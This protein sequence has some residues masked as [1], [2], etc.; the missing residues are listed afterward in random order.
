MLRASVQAETRDEDEA[1]NTYA[2][3]ALRPPEVLVHV[4]ALSTYV[5]KQKSLLGMGDVPLRSIA[6]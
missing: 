1:N 3:G 2:S 5:S 6:R 4:L